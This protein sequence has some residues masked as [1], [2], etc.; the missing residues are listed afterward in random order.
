MISL[1]NSA[2]QG[3]YKETTNKK[4]GKDSSNKETYREILV[5]LHIANEADSKNSRVECIPTLAILSTCQCK[6]TCIND[7]R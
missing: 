2:G 1:L 7:L 6:Q 5:E 4:D 3:K